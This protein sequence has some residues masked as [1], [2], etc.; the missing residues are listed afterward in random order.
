LDFSNVKK[1]SNVIIFH[2]IVDSCCPGVQKF[3]DE[4]KI[5]EKNNYVFYEFKDQ[6]D[7]R[8]RE[9]Y[10]GL[11]VAIKKDFY[12]TI[13]DDIQEDF[14]QYVPSEIIEIVDTNLIT[15][16]VSTKDRYNTTLPLCLQS[17]AAQTKPPS[18]LMIFEDGE[19]KDLEKDP[20]YNNILCSIRNKGTSTKI[21]IGGKNGQV[22][23]H[24]KARHI[25]TT[26]WLYRIDDDHV[27]DST[28]IEK[29]SLHI[30]EGVGAIGGLI[31]NPRNV[32]VMEPATLNVIEDIYDFPNIQWHRHG[33]NKVKKVEHIYSSFLYN[34]ECNSDGYCLKLSRA[35][36]REE[37]MFTYKM[38]KD[39][40]ELLVVP[41]AITWHFDAP[42]GGIRE[43]QKEMFENDENVFKN[44][45]EKYNV[46]FKK[47]KYIILNN[48]LGDLWAFKMALPKIIEGNKDK[49]IFLG[50]PNKGIFKDIKD[51]I[52]TSNDTL[53]KI[54]GD[55]TP[56]NIYH[57]MGLRRWKESMVKAFEE[58]Y[59]GDFGDKK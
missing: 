48:G 40:F 12:D 49:R 20:L 6:Y 56:Y 21:L 50:V 7:K 25:S 11:G 19:E 43:C 39:G 33:N 15:A 37:T 1:Y 42:K 54:V 55:P 18:Y 16:Y 13:K 51:I 27:L 28:C 22:L 5:Q 3:W 9:S 14:E 29:L 58:M 45:L 30:K 17:I 46:A 23:N 24:E 31:L 34:R 38:F 35:G 41:D 2:D 32:D 8:N 57:F 59:S 36:H 47:R 26:K 53:S 4:L 52:L 44:F 10:M